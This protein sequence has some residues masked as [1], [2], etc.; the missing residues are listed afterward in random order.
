MCLGGGA[1]FLPLKTHQPSGYQE[2]KCHKKDVRSTVSY[3]VTGDVAN[4]RSVSLH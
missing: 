2:Q 4:V 3:Y 1:S